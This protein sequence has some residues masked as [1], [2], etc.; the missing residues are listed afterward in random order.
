MFSP[1]IRVAIDISSHGHRVAMAGPDG[2]VSEEFDLAHTGA[3]FE[4]FFQRVGLRSANSGAEGSNQA[5]GGQ[6]CHAR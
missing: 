5:F 1:E 3:A 2:R 6:D 4:E